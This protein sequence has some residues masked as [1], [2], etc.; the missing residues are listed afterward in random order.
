MKHFIF[1]LFLLSSVCLHAE[2]EPD[3]IIGY[4]DFCCIYNHTIKT[5]DL[6]NKEVMDTA[7]TILEIGDN[8]AKYEDYFEY[9]L[10]ENHIPTDYHYARENGDPRSYDYATIYQNYP[11]SGQM[12]IREGLLPH[13]YIYK[14]EPP[15]EWNLVKGQEQVLGHKC[16]KAEVQYAGRT[17][18]AYYAEDI[19]SA[20][21]PWKLTG[22][23]GLVLKAESKDG[24][25][26]FIAQYIFNVD[27]QKITFYKKKKDVMVKRDKFIKLRNKLKTDDRWAKNVGYYVMRADVSS[28]FVYGEKNNVGIAPKF[29][30]NHIS[31][32]LSC[33]FERRFQPLELK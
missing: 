6:K 14:D 10:F 9:I 1:I 15:L 31:I 8:I 19:P 21:G 5:V 18:I 23:P 33:A 12:T 25:H 32:P 22:L 29:E 27:K 24:V 28:I 3:S 13:F 20:N 4:A 26:R 17:W 7:M 11:Q 30:M 2:E 16:K